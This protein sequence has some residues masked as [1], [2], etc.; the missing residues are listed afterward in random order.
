M[1]LILFYLGRNVRQ[2]SGILESLFQKCTPSDLSD[3]KSN[4][5][6]RGRWVGIGDEPMAGNLR[7]EV[8]RRYRKIEGGWLV[9][10]LSCEG[11]V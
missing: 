10:V 9:E 5:W 8:I 6:K 4:G 2:P 11:K 7:C 1:I 3:C